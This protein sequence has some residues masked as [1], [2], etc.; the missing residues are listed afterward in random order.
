VQHL[1][2]FLV[3]EALF[4]ILAGPEVLARNFGGVG[5]AVV[6]S[7]LFSSAS[8]GFRR[9]VVGGLFHGV[10]E[11]VEVLQRALMGAFSIDE[12]PV[13]KA[14]LSCGTSVELCRV[15]TVQPNGLFVSVFLDEVAGDFH[16]WLA[17]VNTGYT[18]IFHAVTNIH[19]FVA[20]STA[21][22]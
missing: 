10:Q 11:F 20:G 8:T 2:L 3:E 14:V 4:E 22:L 9:G 17:D 1:K 7:V 5:I 13:V 19:K 16:S 21:Q 12:N 15:L 6:L 18:A